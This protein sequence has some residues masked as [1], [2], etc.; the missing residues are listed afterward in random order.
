MVMYYLCWYIWKGR[1]R[2][3]NS[4]DKD[5]YRAILKVKRNQ[6]LRIEMFIQNENNEELDFPNHD[7]FQKQGKSDLFKT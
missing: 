1:S 2:L 3:K 4:T 7:F 6:G 5:I